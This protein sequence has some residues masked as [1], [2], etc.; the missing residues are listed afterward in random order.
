LIS[1]LVRNKADWESI[2]KLQIPEKQLI[3]Y[4]SKETPQDLISEINQSKVLLMTD[5]SEGINNNSKPYNPYYYKDFIKK[6]HL[7]III[8]DY[9]VMVSN[10]FCGN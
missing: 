8:S 6:M 2:L 4:V 7:G 9:P 1:A 5:M 3:V 10:I